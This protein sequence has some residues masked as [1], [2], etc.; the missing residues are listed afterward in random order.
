MVLIMI[1]HSFFQDISNFIDEYGNNEVII[2]GDHNC[3]LNPEL[4]YYNYKNINNTK[5]RENVL[6]I[7]NKRYLLDPFQKKIPTTKKLYM[8]KKTRSPCKQARLDFF[9]MSETLFH[10][11]KDLMIYPSYRSD[12]AIV[13]LE[14]NLT[15]LSQENLTGNIIILFS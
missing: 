1:I 8:K 7:M 13:I 3:I 14:L 11:V 9:L 2:C 12:H 15:K 4:D 6:E 5:A 10:Y